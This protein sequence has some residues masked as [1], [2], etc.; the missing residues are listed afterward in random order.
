MMRKDWAEFKIS[1]IVS[2]EGVFI[3]GDWI[4]SKDQDP[5]G[6]I[7]LIQLAD[8]GDGIFVNKS[9]RYLTTQKAIELNCTFLKEGDI[10]VARMP[11]PLGRAVIFPLKGNRQFITVVDVAIIRFANQYIINKYF[12]Y[13]INSPSS[14]RKIE[15]LQS[16]T[17]RKRISRKNLAK[18]TFP[19]A[20]L[21]EQR[22]IV[23]KIDRL[24]SELDN[25]KASLIKAK[26]KLEIYR[27]AVLKNA[28]E[29]KLTKDWREVNKINSDLSFIHL[30]QLANV[31]TGATPKRSNLDYWEKGNIPWVTS[32]ALNNIFVK[33]ASD[34]IT[35]KALED[36][37]C[38]V[39]PAGTLLIA[40]YGEGKT[41][42]KCSELMINAATN[43][44]IAAVLVKHEFQDSKN[45]LKWFFIKNYN[46]IRML[47]SG[48]VQP[49][50]NITKIK[51]TQIPFPSIKEQTQIV[52]EIETRLSVCDNILTN[53]DGALEKAE[54]LRQSILKQAFDGKLLNESELEACRKDPKWEPAEKLLDRINREKK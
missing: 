34:L 22:A 49:N 20:P 19:L 42:G 18:I 41:R 15:E 39:F 23:A 48:G 29:G 43:Q 26:D 24:F 13:N 10:L 4:E 12:L 46:D 36:T 17:T 28:F 31:A 11:H 21:P 54:A 27:Q 30:E 32:G 38:K 7:R 33:E 25:G 37:N 45:Y 2:N 53:I 9:N 14:R 35:E 40:M 1:N 8:I 47:S 16:G 3:D 5:E 52:H 6:D 50:L 44:A 51:E